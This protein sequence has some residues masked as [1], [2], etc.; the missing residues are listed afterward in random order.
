[1]IFLHGPTIL[2]NPLLFLFG[3]GQKDLCRLYSGTEDLCHFSNLT[4]IYEAQSCEC[5]DSSVST[6]TSWP[7]P[8][9]PCPLGETRKGLGTR[10]HV[11]D[12][13]ASHSD[14]VFTP[15][16]AANCLLLRRRSC[17]NLVRDQRP[18]VSLNGGLGLDNI[19]LKEQSVTP[20][21]AHSGHSNRTPQ[22][23]QLINN[24]H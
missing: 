8:G 6:H 9:S 1:M 2:G 7:H 19:E 11:G 17:Y 3:E 4:I 20:A 22:T 12:C 18:A 24:Q 14:L 21:L 23:G 16:S 13:L 15:L 5:G 10:K